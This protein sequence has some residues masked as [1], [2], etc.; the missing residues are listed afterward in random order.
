MASAGATGVLPTYTDFIN[1]NWDMQGQET[2]LI[3]TR[4]TGEKLTVLNTLVTNASNP[5]VLAKTAALQYVAGTYPAVGSGAP[6]A[7]NVMRNTFQNG[8]MC[9]P[10]QRN[11]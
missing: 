8:D 3:P 5:A 10:L 9:Q 2:F 11:N 6:T 4:T 7:S 1:G